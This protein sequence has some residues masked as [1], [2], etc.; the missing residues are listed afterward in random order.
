VRIQQSLGMLPDVDAE[1]LGRIADDVERARELLLGKITEGIPG[2]P[3]R[4]GK[5]AGRLKPSASK[6]RPNRSM[7]GNS[8]KTTC[9]HHV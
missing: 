4:V 7:P 8:D 1:F 9:G 6:P 5:R 3:C 2:L